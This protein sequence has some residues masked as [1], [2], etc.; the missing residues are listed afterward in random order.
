MSVS[1][2]NIASCVILIF[3]VG[4][5]VIMFTKKTNKTANVI[6]SANDAGQVTYGATGRT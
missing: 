3:V 5:M 6:D 4:I 2:L 1:K